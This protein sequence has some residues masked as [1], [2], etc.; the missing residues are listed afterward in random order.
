MKRYALLF[1]GALLLGVA[2]VGLGRIRHAEPKQAPAAAVPVTRDVAIEIGPGGIEP[3]PVAVP[4]GARVLLRVANRTAR[5]VRFG[6]AGYQ[7]RLDVMT[8][9]PGQ[10]GRGEFVADRPGEDFA[11]LVDGSPRG[12]LQVTGSHLM[13]G[14]E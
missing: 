8:L 12:R 10:E 2:L 6:L 11:W 4:K 5:P 3:S 7:D 14:H 9:E 1:V 13:E